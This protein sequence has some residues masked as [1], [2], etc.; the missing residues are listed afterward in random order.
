MCLM[1]SFFRS[2][3]FQ[4][5]FCCNFQSLKQLDEEETLAYLLH[6]LLYLTKTELHVEVAEQSS[7]VMLAEVE[8]EIEGEDV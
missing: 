4:N 7:Q 5:S 8:H 1:I 6:H 2:W 3:F